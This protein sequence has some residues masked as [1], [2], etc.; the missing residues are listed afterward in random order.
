MRVLRGC[1]FAV[2]VGVAIW[3]LLIALAG[4]VPVLVFGGV[5]TVGLA[6]WALIDGARPLPDPEPPYWVSG[7]PRILRESES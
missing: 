6:V 1:L 5:A 4:L 7:S 3:A 2:P